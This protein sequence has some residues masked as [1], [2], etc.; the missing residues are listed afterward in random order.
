MTK[1]KGMRIK[2][3]GAT[4]N[5]G[6]YSSLH[7]TIGEE[8]EFAGLD[9][10]RAETYLRKIAKSVDGVLNL[11]EKED[12]PTEERTPLPEVQ[13]IDGNKM[14]YDHET[15]AYSGEN[16]VEY[17]SVTTMLSEFYPMNP[18]ISQEYLDFAAAYG[19]MVHTAIQ[20]AVIGKPPKKE[21]VKD[22]VEKVL[23]KMDKFDHAVVEQFIQ[24]P[25]EE[26]AGRFDILAY[27]DA[28]ETEAILYDVKT[29]TD[30]Y[31]KRECG[32]PP[33]LQRLFENDWNVETV[34]GEHC[35]QLNIYAYILEKVYGKKIKAIKIIH[36]PDGFK[37]IVDVPKVDITPI[38][39]AYGAIR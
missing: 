13:D 22:T 33:S 14:H 5:L 29:N 39:Q 9:L 8:T 27:C 31:A 28:E 1:N 23:A 11:P 38:F 25:N 16:G 6:N 3:V 20:N 18:A 37:E 26:I 32:L 10:G 7:I 4:I 19:N 17:R 2:D 35:L 15:H 34:Y 24:L 12:K 36:V 30:L 21:M